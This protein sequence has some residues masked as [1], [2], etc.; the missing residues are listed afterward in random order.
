MIMLL[1]FSTSLRKHHSNRPL[2]TTI[3]KA[4]SSTLGS[5]RPP[6]TAALSRL[7]SSS[8]RLSGTKKSS[9]SSF[10]SS[11]GVAKFP[12]DLIT[13]TKSNTVKKIQAL[14]KSAKKRA[15][16]GSTLVEGPR[17]IFDLLKNV[18]TAALVQQIIVDEDKWSQYAIQLQEIFHQQSALL[19]REGDDDNNSDHPVLAE[20]RSLLLAA[21][22][23]VLQACTDT[24]TN[25]GIVAIVD[26]PNTRYNEERLVQDDSSSKDIVRT[27]APPVYLVLDAVSTLET[28]EL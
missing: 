23:K 22:P 3:A 9:D 28:W 11:A 2:T 16:Y 19:R 12:R 27:S 4:I 15:D 13:S 8:N 14:K 1:L 25:Q 7:F 24:V 20:P 10:S 18:R 6:A 21:T 26:I 17:M 5:S